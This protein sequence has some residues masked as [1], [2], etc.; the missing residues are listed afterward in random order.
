VFVFALDI[1]LSCLS[2]FMLLTLVFSA[3]FIIYLIIIRSMCTSFATF[4]DFL[5]K[6]KT[7]APHQQRPTLLAP[8][9]LYERTRHRTRSDRNPLDLIERDLSAGTVIELGGARAFMRRHRLGVFERAA[10]FKVSR[11]AG[12]P[13]GVATNFDGQAQVGGPSPDHVPDIDPVHGLA[14]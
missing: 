8:V 2:G 10:G 14:V 3:G 1:V 9:Y 6:Q 11:D 7:K 5:A 4:S 12:C 13:E